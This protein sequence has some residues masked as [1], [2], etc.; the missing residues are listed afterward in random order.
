MVFPFHYIATYTNTKPDQAQKGFE[1]FWGKNTVPDRND[2]ELWQYYMEWIM[3]D[4]RLKNGSTFLIEYSLT[5]PDNL[6]KNI[7]NQFKQIAETQNY[8]QY[9]VL[10]VKR[11]EYV[12]LEDIYTGKIYKAYDKLGSES[13][14]PES[15]IFA[16]LAK[17]DSKW[18][19][20][21][22][23]PVGMPIT[24]TERMKKMLRRNF[25][26]KKDRLTPKDAYKL[27]LARRENVK[28]SVRFLT[29]KEIKN[30]RKALKK[31]FEKLSLKYNP[32]MTFDSL[33]AEIYNENRVNVLDFW[34]KLAK[35]GLTEDFVMD[36]FQL[37]TD[38]WN[39]F[40]HKCLKDKSPVELYPDTL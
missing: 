30:K 21:G 28:K 33:L 1:K 22:A 25:N 8:S 15:S 19:L 23:N 38:I 9:Q 2:T 31:S 4:F 24:Y 10:G 40:P 14:D 12:E 27:I 37:F 5:N 20:V 17:V 11:G 26:P 18:Y 16:R 29:P 35:K 6:D 32:K 3:F 34:K 7:I 39:H 36:R 13:M